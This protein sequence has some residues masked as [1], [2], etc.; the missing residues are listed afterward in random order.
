MYKI[1]ILFK[2]VDIFFK[3]E[4]AFGVSKQI[5][6]MRAVPFDEGFD[7]TNSLKFISCYIKKGWS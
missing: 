2:Q 3:R 6:S 4:H 5:N 7:G 1:H